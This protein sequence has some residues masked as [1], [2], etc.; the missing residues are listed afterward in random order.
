MQK[1]KEA[2]EVDSNLDAKSK[3][4]LAH[5]AKRMTPSQRAEL[6]YE[7]TLARTVTHE[8]RE[9]A[10]RDVADASNLS[11]W[12]LLHLSDAALDWLA[13]WLAI[14]TDPPM[15]FTAETASIAS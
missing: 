9:N 15:I 4:V 5:L 14:Y 8:H 12:G 10:L 1:F 7:L 2:L 13:R 3:T 11:Q 6:E